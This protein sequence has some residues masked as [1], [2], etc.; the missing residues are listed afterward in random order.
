M[1]YCHL[2]I[3]F[4]NRI[5]AKIE[6]PPFLQ[7]LPSLTDSLMRYMIYSMSGTEVGQELLPPFVIGDPYSLFVLS[8][9]ERIMFG[10]INALQFLGDF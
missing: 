4:T 10:L 3:V 1:D 8:F 2:L 9:D 5:L 6:A 7:T